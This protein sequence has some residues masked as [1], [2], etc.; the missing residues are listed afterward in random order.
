MIRLRENPNAPTYN[1]FQLSKGGLKV[2][3][4]TFTNVANV[5]SII[6]EG[7]S[8]SN[9]TVT[10][11]A[12]QTT[13]KGIVNYIEKAF[14][15]NGFFVESGYRI[16]VVP[17]SSNWNIEILGN[18]KVVSINSPAVNATVVEVNMSQQAPKV[19]L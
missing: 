10:F 17:N 1:T 19:T 18:V 4:N 8:G 7:A 2:Y 11:P 16:K 6:F 12:A 9:V 15:D 3:K 13:W 14:I 5:A